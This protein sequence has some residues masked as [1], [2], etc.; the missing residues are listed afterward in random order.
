MKNKL[1]PEEISNV[2]QEISNL[3]DGLNKSDINFILSAF[4]DIYLDKYLT[5]SKPK[6]LPLCKLF[7]HK[8]EIT[9]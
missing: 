4:D 8:N 1:T 9:G 7:K 6:E 2:T 5:Y 3:L